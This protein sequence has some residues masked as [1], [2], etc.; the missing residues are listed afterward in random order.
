MRRGVL[1]SKAGPVTGVAFLLAFTVSYIVNYHPVPLT[2]VTFMPSGLSLTADTGLW[3][4]LKLQHLAAVELRGE[5][6]I[7][8]LQ[9]VPTD[10][11][12]TESNHSI[13]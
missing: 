3:A 11:R 13:K 2:R 8:M 6:R 9:A 12:L 7:G 5:K 1:V 10:K 4:S